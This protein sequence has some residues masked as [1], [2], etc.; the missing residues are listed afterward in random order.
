MP[1]TPFLN[2]AEFEPESKR[3]MGVAF[4]MARAA[5][6]LSD[7]DEHATKLLAQ[8][9]IDLA[10]QGVLDPDRLCERALNDISEPPKPPIV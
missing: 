8:R 5:L 3:V 1:I 2:G 6:R 4:E 9:I 10:K 7:R